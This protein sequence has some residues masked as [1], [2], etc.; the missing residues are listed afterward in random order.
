MLR[1]AAATL[2]RTPVCEV[3]M[4]HAKENNRHPVGGDRDSACPLLPPLRPQN[5][6]RDRL[7]KV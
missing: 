3:L 2:R 5:R 6:I 4:D 7:F 1:S